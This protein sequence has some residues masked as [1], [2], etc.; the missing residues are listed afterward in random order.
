MR[1][2]I[3][4]IDSDPDTRVVLAALLSHLGYRVAATAS[5]H[6]GVRLARELKPHAIVTEFLVPARGGRCVIERLRAHE[7]TRGIPTIV[8]TATAMPEVAAR[9]RAAGGVYRTKPLSPSELLPDIERLVGEP[10]DEPPSERPPVGGS[11]GAA[12]RRR[13]AVGR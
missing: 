7:A 2:R 4:L 13:P 3:L 11:R 9:V 1:K 8:F 6:Q 10:A 5:A 12:P